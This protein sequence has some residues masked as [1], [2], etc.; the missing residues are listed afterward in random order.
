MESCW[1]NRI[2]GGSGEEGEGQFCTTSTG[3]NRMSWENSQTCDKCS[4]V[5]LKYVA[6]SRARQV[7]WRWVS[8]CLSIDEGFSR[9]EKPSEYLNTMPFG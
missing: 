2:G 7:V 8:V 1:R 6:P 9:R 3:P 5:K 4:L